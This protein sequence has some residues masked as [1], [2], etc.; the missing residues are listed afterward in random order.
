MQEQAE[1]RTPAEIRNVSTQKRVNEGVMA[2]GDPTAE[3]GKSQSKEEV[4]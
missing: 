4:Y 3:D 2:N 1:A